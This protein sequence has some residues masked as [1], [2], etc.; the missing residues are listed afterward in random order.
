[1]CST[2]GG[3]RTTSGSQICA[4][5]MWIPGTYLSFSIS[6]ASAFTQEALLSVP[7]QPYSLSGLSLTIKGATRQGMA[8][9]TCNL[10]MDSSKTGRLPQARSQTRLHHKTLSPPKQNKPTTKKQTKGR[11]RGRKLCW[12]EGR[13][14]EGVADT[15]L[16]PRV[17]ITNNCHHNHLFSTENSKYFLGSSSQWR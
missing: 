13:E 6:K 10:S 4:S 11:E 7:K 1:M 12:E 8:A 14:K 17:I 16:K 5:T 9:Y 3:H 2:C 15:D